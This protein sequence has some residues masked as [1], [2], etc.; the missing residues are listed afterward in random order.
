MYCF[1]TDVLSATIRRDPPMHLVRR[2]ATVPAVDQATTA[3]TAGELLFGVARK[4]S[5]ALTE[6]VQQLLDGAMPILP[7]DLDAAHVYGRLRADLESAGSPLAEPDL[8]IAA[9][10]LSRRAVLV[11]GN[12]RHFERVPGLSIEDWLSE[13]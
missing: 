5:R 8:R 3:I 13:A 10:A 7:F 2:L 12:R 9:I 1:D 11:T 6:R 4:G